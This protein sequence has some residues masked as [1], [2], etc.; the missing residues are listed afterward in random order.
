[1]VQEDFIS[2]YINK[3]DLYLFNTGNASKA[4]QTLGCH[5]I[6]DIGMFL[7]L[8]W[9]PHAKSVSV[10]GSFNHWSS[11]ANP[12]TAI[13]GGFWC[14]FIPNLQYGDLYKYS[15][16]AQDGSLHLKADPFAASAECEPEHASKVYI[17]KDYFWSDNNYLKARSNVNVLASPM[18][19]YEVHIGSWQNISSNKSEIYRSIA[20]PLANYCHRMGFTHVEFLPLNEFPYEG[21]WGYQTTGYF[22]VTSRYGT[23]D[24]FKYLI[25][26]L[27]RENIGV[28][29]DWVPAHFP[30]DGYALAN[31][32][33]TPLYEC[34]EKRM[35]EHPEWGTLI[36]DYSLPEVQSFLISSACQ[37]FEVYH[38]DGV[39]VDAVSS[40]LYLDYGRKPGEWTPN[41]DGNNINY[42]AV[43][44]LQ[45]FNSTVLTAY[46]WA[47]TVAEESTAFPMV[48][49]PPSVGGLGF[50][51]KWD[52]GFMHDTLD[53]MSVDPY[54]RSKCHDK[55][56]FSMMY[57]FSENFILA[58]SHDEVVHGKSSM[59]NKMW[60]EY[61]VKFSSLRTLY[62][63]VFAHPGKKLIFMGS[64][65]AQFIEWD[66]QKH[67]DWLLM[68][69]PRH[70]QMQFYYKDLNSF[71]CNHPPMYEIDNSWEGFKWLNVDDNERSCIAF[72]RLAKDGNQWDYIV[73]ACNFTPVDYED[74]QIALPVYGKLTEVLTSN[75]KKYGGNGKGNLEPVLTDCE[76]FLDMNYSARIKLP[77]LSC[78]YF[79]FIPMQ[80]RALK[81]YSAKGI[82]D[83]GNAERDIG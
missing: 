59:I 45:K 20:L 24:D 60:G 70:K 3:S 55:L 16:T 83:M 48:T 12:M 78:I 74:F 54:F 10:V 35:A 39:R 18:S 7:F 30:K 28:I 37:L 72:L 34:K 29:L 6:S 71:Y 43:S 81:N 44:F 32:D 1:M 8:T 27:H 77:G 17:E 75:D 66:Y 21:S 11:E 19:I 2:K 26:T 15:I 62:G 67:L 42:A 49:Y 46:P 76:P 68:D 61:D 40:M 51:F 69:Y 23:P 5:Y 50:T 47:F 9:A 64:E 65:F 25:D 13:E 33:G 63:F 73:C 31:F 52:M 14:T 41:K 36:F 38:V 57:A 4:W 80:R 22:A 56:T 82:S 79:H 58:F 53:Y